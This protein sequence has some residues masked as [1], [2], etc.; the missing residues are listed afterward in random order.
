MTDTIREYIRSLVSD[1]VFRSGEELFQNGA[2]LD[3]HTQS[4]TVE[5][6]VANETGRFESVSISFRT[7][8][9][10]S[11]CS[12]RVRVPICNHATAVLLRVAQT[13]PDFYGF[14][15]FGDS[16]PA[17]G[18]E[19]ENRTAGTTPLRSEGGASPGSRKEAYEGYL[20]PL[21]HPG[22]THHCCLL[23]HLLDGHNALESRWQH[24]RLKAV[25]Q[26]GDRR[27]S[28]GNMKKMLDGV[29]AA[30]GMTLNDFTPRERQIIR[31][32]SMHSEPQDASVFEIDAT[33]AADLFHCLI[34][35]ER[36]FTDNEQIH[37][38][39]Q[40]ADPCI[41]ISRKDEETIIRGRLELPGTGVLPEGRVVPIAGRGGVW[42]GVQGHYWWL[43]GI[44]DPG[45]LRFFVHSE[46]VAVTETQAAE[47]LRSAHEGRV[48]ARI[49]REEPA[50]EI[51][52]DRPECTP[53]LSLD[54]Q[55]VDVTAELEFDYGSVRVAPLDRRG[56]ETSAGYIVRDAEAE[57]E[58][59][60]LLR[61]LGFV[62][63]SARRCHT[64]SAKAYLWKFLHEEMTNLEAGWRLF[65]SP[66]FVRKWQASDKVQLSLHTVSEGDR[67]FDLRA[68]LPEAEE[69]GL[70]WQDIAEA[71]RTGEDYVTTSDGTLMHIPDDVHRLVDLL[72]AQA[73]RQEENRLSFDISSAFPIAESVSPYL[74]ENDVTP[75]RW[76]KLRDVFLNPDLANRTIE[77][78]E[79]LDSLL[80]DYQREGVAW[81]SMLEETGFHG[82]LADEM[83][84]GKTIQALAALVRRRKQ[85]EVHLPSLVVCPTSLIENWL[86]EAKRFAPQL[87]AMA[88]R[89][90]QRRHLIERLPD[91]DLAITS[92][93]LL[94]RDVG[95]Y[96]KLALD[97]L[98]LDEAQHIKNPGTANAKTC[99]SLSAHHR[100]ILTG[101]PL[102]NSLREVW[103][104]FDYL[105]PGFLGT[106]KEFRQR[107]GNGSTGG[108]EDPR[109]VQELAASIRP[110]ILRRTKDEVC[111]QLPPKIEQ[112]VYCHLD[113]KQQKIHQNLLSAGREMVR[114]A[115]KEGWNTRRFQLLSVIMRLRQ[116]CCHPRMLPA[117][118]LTDDLREAPSAK[119]ELLK[120]IIEE[121]IDGGHRILL[122]SQFT[123]FLSILKDWLVAEDIAFEYLDGS[124]QDRQARVDHF[125]NDPSV[126]I[127]L[128][129]LKAGGTGLNL[130]GADTVIHYDQWW[131]PMVEDQATDRT[132]RIGQDKPVT[133]YK[134]VARHSIEERI[135]NL[136]LRKRQMF[137]QIM[138]GAP[139]KPGELSDEDFEF[140]FG[141][142]RTP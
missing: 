22:R 20:A 99:K 44:V 40:N 73:R 87:K 113:P 94:R 89:G 52:I 41:V 131:N 141:T 16:A 128:L 133:V 82:I 23:L 122:F 138:E 107:F 21:I 47:L 45:W 54:W 31:F 69:V 68:D 35:F 120:E 112:V 28:A 32:L 57:G 93:S 77:L 125:N 110:F 139:T 50:D 39:G 43:P 114:I 119:T 2:V 140:L 6:R 48:R 101:T 61:R 104:L 3:A 121:A 135:R 13:N 111:R 95:H 132:H 79:E 53:V 29:K 58:A 4:K 42:I 75:A 134:L 83:G 108:A 90:L 76:R 116:V 17:N 118:L 102:E 56:G 10:V 15:G 19:V 59:V 136:Q 34:G 14:L 5:A 130:T 51:S 11:R 115:R 97:Y 67:W 1:P 9:I 123:S 8:G 109:A 18:R 92:Y 46:E 63:S 80:R 37:V 117:D 85:G 137:D 129:S 66:A 49:I 24:M 126:P 106:Q 72:V 33:R 91:V 96:E 70:S 100:L 30:G 55:S 124:T 38:H 71:C 105:L 36:F 27:Y 64:L 26:M 84:L 103:S 88:V 65:M 74:G 25:L 7:N 12:C 98:I 60:G 78:S 62:W 127:F 142:H 81:L 86:I